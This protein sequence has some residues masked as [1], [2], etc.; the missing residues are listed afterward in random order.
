MSS[1]TLF[2]KYGG[3]STISELVVDFYHRLLK[4][5]KLSH[6]FKD[7]DMS[8]IMQH[9]IEIFTAAFGGE[10]NYS[11]LELGAAHSQLNIS[12]AD[13]DDLCECLIE[14]MQALGIEA[15]DIKIVMEL[16]EKERVKIVT[17]F[18]P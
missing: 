17:N 9:Q 16:M 3:P 2:E 6:F 1:V 5:P 14:T 4:N 7:S 15:E 10:N 8:V 18:I 11:G 13:Y 12:M